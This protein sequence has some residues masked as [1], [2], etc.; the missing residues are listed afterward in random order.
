MNRDPKGQII[1]I[2]QNFVLK[3]CRV[4]IYIIRAIFNVRQFSFALS[5]LE[6]CE[7]SFMFFFSLFLLVFYMGKQI[8]SIEKFSIYW[9]IATKLT[10]FFHSECDSC[11][12]SAVKFPT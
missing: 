12:I 11:R 5:P 1:Q 4:S 10:L 6:N 3:N 7:T 9:N 2:C 8:N